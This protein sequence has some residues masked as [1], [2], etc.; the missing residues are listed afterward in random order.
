MKQW[1]KQILKKP[2]MIH[3]LA[4]IIAKYINFVFRTTKWQKRGWQYPEQYWR[5][6]KPFI[7][8]FWHNRLLMTCFAWEGPSAFHMLISAHADGQLIAQTVAHYGV[9]TIA[10]SKSKGGA[11]ALRA[12][13]K[14]LKSGYTVGITPDGPRGPRFKASEGIAAAAKLAKL[15]ILPVTYSTTRRFVLG[16]WDRFILALPFGRG[17][18]A[19]GKPISYASFYKDELA[20]IAEVVEKR[21]ETL[22]DEVDAYCDHPPLR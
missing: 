16:S 22:C 13:L 10:G 1:L 11:A 12:I 20:K 9:K 8:C 14:A 15:D 17:V 2:Q 19:W 7:T 6:G 18:L 5:E 3:F 4:W 21:L